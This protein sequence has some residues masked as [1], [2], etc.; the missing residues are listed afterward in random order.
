MVA[1]L[2]NVETVLR[3]LIALIW[4]KLAFMIANVVFVQE[5]NSAN[6]ANVIAA[7]VLSRGDLINTFGRR[8]IDIIQST[9]LRECH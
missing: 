4:M 7:T 1:I 5:F 3:A 9:S 8:N 6:V 2:I